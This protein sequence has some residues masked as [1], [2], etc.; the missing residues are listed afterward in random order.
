VTEPHPGADLHQLCVDG[1]RRG[2]RWDPELLGGSPEEQRLAHRVARRQLQQPPGVRGQGIEPPA[3]AVLDAAGQPDRSR[4]GKAARQFRAHPARELQQGKRIAASLL[5]DPVKNALVD[6]ARNDRRQ[7]RPCVCV[8]EPPQRQLG[9][10]GKRVPG[11]RLAD[12]EHKRDRL[13]QEPSSDELER[14]GRRVVRPLQ[15]VHQAQERLVLRRGRQHAECGERDEEA[16]RRIAGRQA[17]RDAKGDPLRLGERVQPVE[18]LRAQL[19]QARVRQLHLRLDARDLSDP[20]PGG[21]L[22][23]VTQQRRL[24]DARFPAD[25]DHGALPAAHVVKQPIQQRT[26]TRPAPEPRRALGSHRCARATGHT[27]APTRD[28]PGAT[29]HPKRDRDGTQHDPTEATMSTTETKTLHLF[30]TRGVSAIAWAAV[31]A[32]A[33]DSLTVGAAVLLVLYPLIDV[34]ASLNDARTQHGSARRLLLAGAAASAVAAVAL[35]VAATGSV[36]NV[37]AVFGI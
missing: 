24:A 26:L 32:V 36:S 9:Q 20:K 31:F 23:G 18:H 11:A 14:L 27:R 7:Q 35:G 2:L 29:D 13:R 37:L 12:G 34:V 3:K 6:P 10:A 30:L 8:V 1:R 25:D 33:S 19:V 15:I 17:Q 5:N 22:N 16:I 21:P 4:D 28:H